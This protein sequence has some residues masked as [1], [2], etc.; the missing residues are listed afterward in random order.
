MGAPE[1]LAA[2]RH[3]TLPDEEKE[4]RAETREDSDE[5]GVFVE[6][7]KRRGWAASS[8][9]MRDICARIEAAFR[10]STVLA[11]SIL[12]VSLQASTR[13]PLQLTNNTTLSYGMMTERRYPA[14]PSR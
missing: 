1:W 8:A 14:I 6:I 3:P 7:V 4:E 11:Y 9:G 10:A 2:D 13:Q 5:T 12:R